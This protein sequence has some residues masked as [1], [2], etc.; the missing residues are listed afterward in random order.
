M[1]DNNPPNSQAPGPD[2]A[3]PGPSQE[4]A[5]QAPTTE[6]ELSGEEMVA[7]IRIALPT[8]DPPFRTATEAAL[9]AS[10]PHLNDPQQRTSAVMRIRRAYTLVMEN[11]PLTSAELMKLPAV[12]MPNYHKFGGIGIDC[13]ECRKGIPTGLVVVKLPCGH[14]LHRNCAVRALGGR[15][16]RC[17][18]GC[19]K[20][21]RPNPRAS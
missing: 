4:P 8:M 13:Q 10:L 19:D 15:Q 21:P 20:R 7:A 6:P 17:P 18:H 14:Y 11:K 12:R 9:N 16:N 1:T 5:Q 3:Q 2:P